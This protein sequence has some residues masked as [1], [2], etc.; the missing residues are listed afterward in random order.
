MVGEAENGKKKKAMG[1]D[2]GKEVEMNKGDERLVRVATKGVFQFPTKE[3]EGVQGGE[4]GTFNQ[5][6]GGGQKGVKKNIA[7]FGMNIGNEWL[8]YILFNLL[9]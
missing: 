2:D 1:N 7:I 8:T 4:N 3:E 9:L 6:R 5:W